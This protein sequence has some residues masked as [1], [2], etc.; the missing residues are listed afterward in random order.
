[1][2]AYVFVAYLDIEAA[3]RRIH[4]SF[5][6]VL[7]AD[8]AAAAADL[9]VNVAAIRSAEGE[10]GCAL[11]ADPAAFPLGNAETPKQWAKANP[12][13]MVCRFANLRPGAYAVTVFHDLNGN[14]KPD[15]SFLGIPSEDWG[16]SNNVR[17]TLR[18]PTF[19]EAKFD[20]L[21]ERVTVVEIR[22]GR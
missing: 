15:T 3:M 2:P 19:D 9:V 16:A 6:F 22:L 14:R 17:P 18:A 11:H 20:V 1:L 10:V 7:L 21:P 13:G 4:L 12:A 5:L 8:N